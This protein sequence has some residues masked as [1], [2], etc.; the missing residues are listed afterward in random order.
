MDIKYT[1]YL[2]G[3]GHKIVITDKDCNSISKDD[4]DKIFSDKMNINRLL[5]FFTKNDALYLKPNEVQ[6]VLVSSSQDEI[7]LTKSIVDSEEELH[8]PEFEESF[9]EYLEKFHEA[10][11]L[12]PLREKKAIDEEIEV[13]LK[14][15]IAKYFETHK[16]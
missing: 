5:S 16:R 11:L 8:I 6:A 14:E 3:G 13:K 12:A 9:M 2:K 15:V 10:D 7:D 4:L 1:F